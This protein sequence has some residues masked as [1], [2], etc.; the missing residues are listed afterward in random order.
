MKRLFLLL[1]YLAATTLAVA[2]EQRIQN[3]PYL[4]TRFL[5]YGFFVG[6]DMMDLELKNNGY[7]DPESGEQWYTEVDNYQPGFVVGVLGELRLN[8]YLGLRLQ[9]SIHFGQ[10]HIVFHEQLSGRDSTQNI[11]S[12]YLSVPLSLKI[13]APRYN[14]FRPYFS[15]GVSP[16][17]DLTARKHRA[18]RTEMLDCYIELAAGCDIYLPFFKLIPEL[19]FSFGLRDVLVHD[20]DDLVDLSLLKFTKGLDKGHSK[21]ITLA[22]YFE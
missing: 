16:T 19:R 1:A 14:N 11:K 5:H 6:V 9:P 17:I 4:D 3:R 8:K 18:L 7:V 10:K 21:M 20:R 22:F 2:Q 13:A 15:V 12:T